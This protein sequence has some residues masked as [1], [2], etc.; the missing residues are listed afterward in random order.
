MYYRRQLEEDLDLDGYR[1]QIRDEDASGYLLAVSYQLTH[2]SGK[3]LAKGKNF[4]ASPNVERDDLI[5]TL[6]KFL[7]QGNEEELEDLIP[8]T[9]PPELCEGCE[10]EGCEECDQTGFY[11]GGPCNGSI[12][13][14]WKHQIS[15]YPLT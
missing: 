13:R 4:Q 6:L 7:I 2:P 12:Y 15:S 3:I 1:L 9:Q 14:T 8:W 5:R 11:G 10:G